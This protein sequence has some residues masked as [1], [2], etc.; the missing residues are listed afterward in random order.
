M[1]INIFSLQKNIKK[2]G[3]THHVKINMAAKMCVQMT[4][5][6][7]LLPLHEIERG[8]EEIKTYAQANNVQLPRFFTY[9]YR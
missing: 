8:F 6:L 4:A 7:A 3:Y 2:L 5:A 1:F 9:F